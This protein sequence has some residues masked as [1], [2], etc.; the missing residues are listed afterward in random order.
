DDHHTNGPDVLGQFDIVSL[1]LPRFELEGAEEAYDGRKAR[2][3]LVRALDDHVAAAER[4]QPFELGAVRTGDLIVKIP[5]RNAE[6]LTLVEFVVKVRRPEAREIEQ[7]FVDDR[8]RVS[9]R[10]LVA[11]ADL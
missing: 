4:E 9:H 8:E 6:R 7:T 10:A 1:L 11:L 5:R 2:L 3:A